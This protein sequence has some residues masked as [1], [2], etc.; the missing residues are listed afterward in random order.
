MRGDDTVFST[1]SLSLPGGERDS[2][3]QRSNAEL[4]LNLGEG[5]RCPIGGCNGGRRAIVSKTKFELP[6]FGRANG[7]ILRCMCVNAAFRWIGAGS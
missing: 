6:D 2:E 5:E 3:T 1:H 4:M 7:G